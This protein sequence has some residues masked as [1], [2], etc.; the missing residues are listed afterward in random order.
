MV[1]SLRCPKCG[2][3]GLEKTQSDELLCAACG[4]R[5]VVT[6][7]QTDSRVPCPQCGFRNEPQASSCTECGTALAKYC[8]RCGTRLEVSMRFCD[9]CGANYE[10]LSSPDGRCQW[11]GSQN[12]EDAMVCDNCGARLIATCPNCE[13]TMKAGLNYCKACGLDYTTLLEPEEDET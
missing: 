10:A 2:G 3:L 12:E 13:A 11:C 7:T 8:P 9:Q 4:T 1:E 6:S 5:F